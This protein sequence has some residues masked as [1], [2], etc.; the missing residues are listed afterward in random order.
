M[1]QTLAYASGTPG[2]IAVD[3]SFVYWVDTSNNAAFRMPLAGGTPQKLAS[4]PGAMPG[5]SGIAV[6]GNS[7]YWTNQGGAVMQAPSAGGSPTTIAIEPY[8]TTG[9]AS[10]GSSIFWAT[11]DFDGNIFKTPIGGDASVVLSEAHHANAVAAD[12]NNVYWTGAAQVLQVA[13]NGGTSLLVADEIGTEPYGLSVNGTSVYWTDNLNGR[14]FRS[15][16]S[17]GSSTPPPA[18]ALAIGQAHPTFLTT[19]DVSVYF[20][21]INAVMRIP[22]EGGM[23]M[24]IADDQAN[25]MA[26][27][28]DY[29][30]WTSVSGAIVRI[31][32]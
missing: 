24:K 17:A 30:Y 20:T 16:I 1:P 7:V 2:P 10:D 22:E 8:P 29:V 27:D 28:D 3:A 18:T 14:V 19:D 32:K 9:I 6:A 31:A 13:I 4:G 26:I 25:G 5:L 12:A 23:P 15:P 21:T 11:S